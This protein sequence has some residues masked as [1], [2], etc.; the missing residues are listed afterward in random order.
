MFALA[1]FALHYSIFFYPMVISQIVSKVDASVLQS[2]T[3]VLAPTGTRLCPLPFHEEFRCCV[4][5]YN[6]K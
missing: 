2:T 4:Q 5:I 6:L 1:V 3:P